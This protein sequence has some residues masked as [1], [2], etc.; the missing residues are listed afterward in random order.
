MTM[1]NEEVYA[2][3]RL[4]ELVHLRQPDGRTFEVARRAPGV[5]VIIAD[6]VAR[7]VL[8]QREFRRELKA[9]DFRLPGGKVFDSLEEFD[10]FRKSGQD[11]TLAAAAKA[12]AEAHEEAGIAVEDVRFYK[13]SVL[14]A[15]VAWD[16]F[17]FE[18]TKWHEHENRQALEAGE[19]I[20]GIIW[21]DFAEL[22]RMI[23][24][25]DLQE[26]R[27][28]LVILQWLHGQKV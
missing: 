14:G 15:T 20:D 17:V 2:R 21:C 16:L 22:E 18:A 4:F 1:D 25:G 3:G 9:Y 12:K 26:E 10:T 23:I 6:K 19:Q 7:K 11:I 5:R 28:A 8:L 24:R 27:I 13:K